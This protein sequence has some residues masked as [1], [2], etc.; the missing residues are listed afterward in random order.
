MLTNYIIEDYEFN[1]FQKK[2]MKKFIEVVR[3][4]M[5]LSIIKE[6]IRENMYKGVGPDVSI[7]WLSGQIEKVED[8]DG[9][10]KI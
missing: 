1:P 8:E 7:L 4:D 5:S 10:I 9:G 2:V 6:A 3:P